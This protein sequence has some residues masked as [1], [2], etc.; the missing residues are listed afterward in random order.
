MTEWRE[1]MLQH[2]R[3]VILEAAA[4]VFAVKGFAR[5]TIKEIADRAGIA[6]GTIYLYFENKRELLLS[7]AE[8]LAQ[9][10]P[11]ELELSMQDVP[12]ELLVQQALEQALLAVHSRWA[13]IRALAAEMW[14]DEELRRDY[15]LQ[16]LGPMLEA[17]ETRLQVHITRNE[18]RALDTGVAARAMVGAVAAA[19]IAAEIGVEDLDDPARRQH[20]SRELTCFF[21]YGLRGQS[22]EGCV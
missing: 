1:E 14:T 3:A 10:V 6:P 4:S 22:P 17:F 16:G 18:I 8:Q 13:F 7:I 20:L 9:L 5:A 19:L 12:E 15:L 21:M 2:R 11:G